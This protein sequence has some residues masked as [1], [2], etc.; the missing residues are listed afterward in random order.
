MMKLTTLAVLATFALTG[1]MNLTPVGRYF[2]ERADKQARLEQELKSWQHF[3][4]A[5]YCGERLGDPNMYQYG[6]K[7]MAAEVKKLGRDPR[8]EVGSVIKGMGQSCIQFSNFVY[9]RGYI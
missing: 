7:G 3:R 9:A 4:A 2:N 8:A 1:C 6:V 5:E